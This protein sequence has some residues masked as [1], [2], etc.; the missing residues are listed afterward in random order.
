VCDSVVLVVLLNQIR[1]LEASNGR[2]PRAD[3]NPAVKHGRRKN[4]QL[5][6]L[7]ISPKVDTAANSNRHFSGKKR[8]EWGQTGTVDKVNIL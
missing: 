5:L 8:R 4:K 6:L 2:P 1:V 7:C 3:I